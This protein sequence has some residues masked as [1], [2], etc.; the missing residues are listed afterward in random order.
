[1]N[2]LTLLALFFPSAT[3]VGQVTDVAPRE[4]SSQMSIESR[5]LTGPNDMI[6][7]GRNIVVP[8]ANPSNHPYSTTLSMEQ[9]RRLVDRYPTL[10]PESKAQLATTYGGCADKVKANAVEPSGATRVER[11]RPMERGVESPPSK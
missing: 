3:V 8:S 11:T 1:M 4:G 6:S 5:G 2:R 7:G 10:P 9:C